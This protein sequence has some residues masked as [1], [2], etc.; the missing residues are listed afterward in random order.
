MVWATAATKQATTWPHM[1]DH[2]LSTIVKVVAGM[3]YWVVFR[4]KLDEDGMTL[5]C[6]LGCNTSFVDERWD[7]SSAN[8]RSWDHEGVLLRAGDILYGFVIMN[9]NLS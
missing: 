2:G 9:H 5:R 1:D 7:P 8:A 4:E 6:D 3:K